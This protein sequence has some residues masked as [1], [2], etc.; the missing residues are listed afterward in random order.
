[1]KIFDDFVSGSILE[2]IRKKKV[3]LEVKAEDKDSKKNSQISY[4]LLK[5]FDGDGDFEIDIRN[6]KLWATKM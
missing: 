2:N 5:D 3:V 1:M 4:S 6:G